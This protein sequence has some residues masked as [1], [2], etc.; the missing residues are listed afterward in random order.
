MKKILLSGLGAVPI[1]LFAF[2]SGPPVKRTGAA[3]DGGLTCAVCHSN[4]G[5]ANSDPKGSVTISAASYAPG[6]KQ[7]VTVSVKH[8]DALRWGFQLIAR[9]RKSVV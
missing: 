4:L 5:P 7:M 2:S 3:V 6:V 9:D 1:M 8:P